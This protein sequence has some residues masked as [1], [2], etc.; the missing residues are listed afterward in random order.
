MDTL[1]LSASYEPV[2]RIGWQRA[3]TL[4]WENKVEIVEEYED[5]WV[6]SV[7]LEFKM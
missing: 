4:L 1:V 3:I 7:T 6:R 2:A 5:K